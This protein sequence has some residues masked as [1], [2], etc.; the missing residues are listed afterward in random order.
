MSDPYVCV[1][2]WAPNIALRSK[3]LMA[4]HLET[5]LLDDET[6]SLLLARERRRARNLGTLPKGGRRYPYVY[7]YVH[8]HIL[9]KNSKREI[10]TYIY[11]Y[12]HVYIYIYMYVHILIYDTHIQINICIPVDGSIF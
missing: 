6:Q 3:I 5:R 1:S 8:I 11:I 2:A 9:L 12:I 7:T 10:R 4:V